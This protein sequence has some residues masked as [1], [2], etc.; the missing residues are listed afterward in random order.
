MIKNSGGVCFSEQLQSSI[1]GI[2]S[3]VFVWTIKF[4]DVSKCSRKKK[5][6]EYENDC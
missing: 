6:I 1:C 4:E 5:A 3:F 2:M